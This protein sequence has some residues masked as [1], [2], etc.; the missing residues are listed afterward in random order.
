MNSE[1][2]AVLFDI[3]GVLV[4]LD[5][6]RALASLLN[7][8]A[9]HD[10]ILKL[11]MSSPSVIAHES[12]RITADEFAIGFVGEFKLPITP[13]RFLSDFVDW[14]SYLH[15]GSLELLE[16]IPEAYMVAALSNTSAV[17]WE[18]I[19][20]M[21]LGPQFS[22]IYLSYEIGCLK[23]SGDAF[24]AALDGMNLNPEQVLFLDDGAANVSAAKRLGF[25]AHLARGPQEA[26][27][28]LARFGIV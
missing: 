24:R 5:G 27:S 18:K 10:S 9:S 3:G 14:A 25:N 15:A 26:R 13:A 23:P 4:A 2:A 20:G 6:V 19:Q 16:E 7:V 12:G 8:D 22:Q 11:W 17:H 1:I 28:V 21:G